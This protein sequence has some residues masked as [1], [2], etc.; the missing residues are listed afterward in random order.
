MYRG[1]DKTNFFTNLPLISITIYSSLATLISIEKKSVRI[2]GGLYYERVDFTENGCFLPI[3]GGLCR[4]R[5]DFCRE[6][7]IR[8]PGVMVNGSTYRILQTLVSTSDVRKLKSIRQMDLLALSIFVL[9]QWNSK[10]A[11]MSIVM[12]NVNYCSNICIFRFKSSLPNFKYI[13]NVSPQAQMF[14]Q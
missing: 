6:R 4:E 12:S 11:N 14:V 13:Q 5:V 3:T 10:Y 9:L 8:F 7:A 2:T 1:P